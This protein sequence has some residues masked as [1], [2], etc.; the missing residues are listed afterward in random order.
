MK[1]IQKVQ[2]ELATID[3]DAMAKARKEFNVKYKEKM[4]EENN[5]NNA[6][7]LRPLFLATSLPASRHK[8]IFQWQKASG[9]LIAMADNRAKLEQT[10]KMDY[11]NIDKQFK[12]QLIKTK[13]SSRF[14]VYTLRPKLWAWQLTLLRS[15][16]LPTTIS[17]SIAKPSTMLS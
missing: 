10:L 13:V 3:L 8:L 16:S 15:A 14:L 4:E 1:E 12:D 9:Q 17:T 7:S 6:V 5:V 2:D 11:K